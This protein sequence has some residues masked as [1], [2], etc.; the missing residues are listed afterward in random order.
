MAGK[1]SPLFGTCQF[2]LLFNIY[3]LLPSLEAISMG[4]PSPIRTPQGFP[5]SFLSSSPL[6]FWNSA[7]LRDPTSRAWNSKW[8]WFHSNH[9]LYLL[10]LGSWRYCLGFWPRGVIKRQVFWNPS[11]VFLI[12]YYCE[13]SVGFEWMV[14]VRRNLWFFSIYS[15]NQFRIASNLLISWQ[16]IKNWWLCL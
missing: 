4:E 10:C 12:L 5:F 14:R 8:L 9:Q 7:P 1:P 3:I 2:N 16:I 13:V 15:V 6:L 11:Y